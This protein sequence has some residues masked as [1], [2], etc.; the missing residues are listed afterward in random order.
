M[1]RTTERLAS[2]HFTTWTLVVLFLWFAWGL[3]LSGMEGFYEGFESMNSMLVRDWLFGTAGEYALLKIWF[4]GL[5]L[6]MVILG[7]NLVFCS[8]H[9][10]LKMMKVRF[11]VPKFIM[12][13][14]HIVF[15]LV[16]V[17]HFCTFMIGFQ[18]EKVPL[19]EGRSFSFE[20]GY[21][22]KVKKV[23]FVDEFKTLFK[24]RRE[25]T[26][27]EFHYKSNFVE[28]V[29]N[30]KGVPVLEDEVFILK[31]VRYKDIQI[32]LR[33]FA[34]MGLK[35]NKGRGNSKS[36]KS[37]PGVVFSLTGSPVTHSFL[38]LYPIMIAGM[39]GY[40]IMTWRNTNR[41]HNNSQN[42]LE[43]LTTI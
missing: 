33:R 27:E 4:V 43:T 14:I 21:E 36:T 12:L 26:G 20:D 19:R 13:I 22:L 28:V 8:W 9:K 7:I 10:I 17:G 1:K 5:C 30:H 11:H 24:S 16:A 15:G 25:L 31:P 18:H 38:F 2:L 41:R 34:P 40:L 32:T 29:L 42:K 23:H 35:G 39:C 6:V 3:L 37:V